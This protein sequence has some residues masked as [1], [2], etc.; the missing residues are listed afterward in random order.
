MIFDLFAIAT[1]LEF[2]R[3]LL[4]AM[5]DVTA[6]YWNLLWG[7]FIALGGFVFVLGC[8]LLKVRLSETKHIKDQ[9]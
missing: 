9:L 3:K 4:V 7:G 8:S 2:W 1:G 6:P 5:F